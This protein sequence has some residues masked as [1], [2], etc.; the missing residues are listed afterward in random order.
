MEAEESGQGSVVGPLHGVGKKTGRE[1][2]L[3]PVITQTF[4]TDALPRAGF[5]AAVADG[6][7]LFSET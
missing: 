2:I 4:A 7:V 3:A 6:R 1:F 5:I